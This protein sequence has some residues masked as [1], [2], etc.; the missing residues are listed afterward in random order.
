MSVEHSKAHM[1]VHGG[2]GEL[3]R[4]NAKIIDDDSDEGREMRR[5][6]HDHYQNN[7]GENKDLGIEM[8]FRYHSEVNILDGTDE[9]S[10]TPSKYM[11]STFPGARAPHIFLKDGTAIFDLYGKDFTLI[12]FT[13]DIDRGGKLLVGAAQEK[14]IPLKHVVLHG[15][16]HAAKIWEKHLVLVRPDGHVAW[17]SDF[18]LDRATARAIVETVTGNVSPKSVN[19]KRTVVREAFAVSGSGVVT[20]QKDSFALERMGDL[21]K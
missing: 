19:E 9:P 8:G 4:P 13:D 14:S 20:T 18:L 3:L 12:E 11:P 5:K 6:I 21:Q 1:A 15:E 2:L 16:D 17:R 10:W 7:D